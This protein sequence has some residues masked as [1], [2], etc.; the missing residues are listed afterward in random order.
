MQF[1]LLRA[2]LEAYML[3]KE[4]ARGQQRISAACADNKISE[5]DPLLKAWLAR[6]LSQP[7]GSSQSNAPHHTTTATAGKRCRGSSM[8]SLPEQTLK[9]R[10]ME[11][12]L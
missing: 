3:K 6:C 7:S 9:R 1:R 4:A 2:R 11:S 12:K 10:Q 5:Q 8:D